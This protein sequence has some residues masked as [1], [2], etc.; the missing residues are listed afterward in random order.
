MTNPCL[1]CGACCAFFRVSF[2]WAE[3]D[4]ATPGGVPVE[5]TE[6]LNDTR[7]VMKGTDQQAPRC[8][9]LG[10]EPGTSVSC[11]IYERRPSVCAEF[12][13]SWYEGVHNERCDEAR[14]ARGLAA[15]TPESFDGPTDLPSV[16]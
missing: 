3:G 7:R 10:G 16:A 9:G 4:D 2:Y 14:A 15:L 11:T 5:L 6:K 8:V 1:T 13:P 12:M